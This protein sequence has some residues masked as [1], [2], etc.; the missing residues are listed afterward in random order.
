MKRFQFIFGFL[1][2]F[3]FVHVLFYLKK[4][5]NNNKLLQKTEYNLTFFREKLYD[6]QKPFR[7][8]SV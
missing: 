8:R 3:F 4:K 5:L 2:F 7:N 6:R 1:L